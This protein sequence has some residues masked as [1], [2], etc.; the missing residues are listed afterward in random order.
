MPTNTEYAKFFEVDIDTVLKERFEAG[1]G[2]I[3]LTADMPDVAMLLAIKHAASFGKPFMVVPSS[4]PMDDTHSSVDIA[5]VSLYVPLMDEATSYP[6]PAM[7]DLMNRTKQPTKQ[8]MLDRIDLLSGEM[9]ANEEENKMMQDEIT[10]LYA[11]ID[12][13]T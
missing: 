3:Q 12:A 4:V 8:E 13:L 7:L 11:K 6:S 2:V 5:G 10:T 1:Q 9:D